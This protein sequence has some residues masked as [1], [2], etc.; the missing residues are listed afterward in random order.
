MTNPQT[1]MMS[2]INFGFILDK[3]PNTNYLVQKVEIP[4]MQ[5]GIAQTPSPGLVRII[6]PGNIEYGDLAITFKVGEDMSDY[7]EIYNWMIELGHPDTLDQY[8]R[9]FYDAT[10]LIMDS[11]KRPKIS[12]RFT[13]CIPVSLSQVNLDSTMEGVQYLDATATFRFQRF[14]YTIL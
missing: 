9:S 4:G 11:A 3:T 8:S 1:S 2:P 13:D 6:N 7:L 14:F 12:V 5:L 10:V